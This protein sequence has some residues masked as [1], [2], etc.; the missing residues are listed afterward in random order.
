MYQTLLID[1][2]LYTD[3][4]PN[5]PLGPSGSADSALGALKE[6]P[7]CTGTDLML[8]EDRSVLMKGTFPFHVKIFCVH[9]LTHREGQL[10]EMW[11]QVHESRLAS[12]SKNTLDGSP[13]ML[14]YNIIYTSS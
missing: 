6:I 8:D 12:K 3:M 14:P 5:F 1:G 11:T 7:H 10:F 13:T 4:T 2:S 9:T